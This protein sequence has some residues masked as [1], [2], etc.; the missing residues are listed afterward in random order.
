MNL[1][2]KWPSQDPAD[3]IWFLFRRTMEEA[4]NRFGLFLSGYVYKNS[5]MMM[6]QMG[7]YQG[8]FGF[9]IPADKS[10]DAPPAYF[11]EAYIQPHLRTLVELRDKRE[12]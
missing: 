4:E 8:Q 11:F 7:N 6:A 5:G 9:A 3:N 1:D 12:P 2:E 10:T